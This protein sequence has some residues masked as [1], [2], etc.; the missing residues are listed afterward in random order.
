MT[1]IT[2][3]ENSTKTNAQFYED[4][5]TFPNGKVLVDAEAYW[6]LR[7]DVSVVEKMLEDNLKILAELKNRM[8]FIHDEQSIAAFDFP[9]QDVLSR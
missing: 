1:I 9:I 5:Q 3:T 8:R 2:T 6:R 7:K 4:V